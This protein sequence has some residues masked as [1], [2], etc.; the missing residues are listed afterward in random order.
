MGF[1]IQDDYYSAAVETLTK[2]EQEQY[3]ATLIR[4]YFD[5]LFRADDERMTK[6]VRGMFSAVKVRIDRARKDAERKRT[7]R[8]QSEDNPRTFCAGPIQS[9][10]EKEKKK[11]KKKEKTA[12]PASSP[13][14]KC[15][16]ARGAIVAG[17]YRCDECDIT[18]KGAAS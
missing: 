4:Y 7:I 16:E 1:Y 6:A 2:R 10:K 12:P 8:G 3:W 5:P 13:C 9:E 18:W 15:G 14:P 11:E 17:M